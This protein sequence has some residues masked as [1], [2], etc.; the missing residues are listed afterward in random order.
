[1]DSLMEM[2]E[3]NI[4][5]VVYGD[6]VFDSEKGFTI[7]STERLLSLLARELVKRKSKVE[8]IIHCGETDGVIVDEKVVKEIRADNFEEIK[9]SI[10]KTEGFDVTGGMLHKVEES[11]EMAQDGI[12]SFIVGGNHG[13]NMYRAVVGDKFIGTRITK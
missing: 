2:L 7:W 13:G 6:I 8:K 9:K 10:Y 12:D 4:I 11:L 3:L 1:M 5:P